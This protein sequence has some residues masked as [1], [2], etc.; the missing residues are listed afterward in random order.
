MSSFAAIVE[1][2]VGGVNY[3]TSLSTLTC[4]PNSLLGDLFTGKTAISK[5]SQVCNST[6]NDIYFAIKP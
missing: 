4:E 1:L 3:T 5:D 6:T 2:N